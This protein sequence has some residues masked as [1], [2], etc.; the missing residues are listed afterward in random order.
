MAKRRHRKN[1]KKRRNIKGVVLGV[2][3]FAIVAV[4][5]VLSVTVF[6]NANSIK[7]KGDTRYTDSQI[8]KAVGLKKGDNMFLISDKKLLED[9]SSSLPYIEE[10]KVKRILPDKLEL[11]IKE[12]EPDFAF[13]VK[14]GYL[15]T[16]KDRALEVVDAVDNN[17]ALVNCKLKEYELG[18]EVELGDNKELFEKIA[19]AIENT[20]LKKIT[21]ID[22]SNSAKIILKYD[23]RLTLELGTIDNLETKF[24]KAKQIIPS[25]EKDNGNAVQGVIKL[26]FTDS[27]FERTFE[28]SSST[29]QSKSNKPESTSTASK[30]Q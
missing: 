17:V 2:V 9:A 14:D 30:N 11:T 20:E 18:E 1:S 26:Q 13:K 3:C 19:A 6:F 7:I 15:I 24:K 22:F 25:V 27:Y 29:A 10:V 8:L 23:N 5:I 21:Y 28:D 12:A 16:S 4:L